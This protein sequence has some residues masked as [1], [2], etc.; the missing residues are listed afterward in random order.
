[1]LQRYISLVLDHCPVLGVSTLDTI[2]SDMNHLK[3]TRNG[4][5]KEPNGNKSQAGTFGVGIG[6]VSKLK[7]YVLVVC[8]ITWVFH[9]SLG[10]SPQWP[11]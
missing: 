4:S 11:I 6:S 3:Q 5:I 10:W 2:K 1:M 9:S 8:M 7:M